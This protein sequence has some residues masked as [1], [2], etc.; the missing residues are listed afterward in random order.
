MVKT[1]G[2]DLKDLLAFRPDDTAD[3]AVLVRNSAGPPSRKVPFEGFRF[4]DPLKGRST[5]V[6]DHGVQPA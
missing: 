4:A 2:G 3:K 5:N 1:A 6:V